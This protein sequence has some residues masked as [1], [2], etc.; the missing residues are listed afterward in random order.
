MGRIIFSVEGPVATIE[1]DNPGAHNAVD[2][3]MRESLVAAYERVEAD[4]DIRVAIMRG[5]GG[6]FCAGGSI[7][8]YLEAKVFGPD[9]DALP[10][11]P[12]PYPARKP[13]IAAMTGYALG[14]GFALALS[15]D[16]RV[17]GRGAKMGP[18]GMKFGAVQGAQTISR[19]TR[20]IGASRAL[21]VLL[22]SKRID[23]EEAERIGLA[24]AL[25][26]D[27]EVF[28]T[29]R[30]MAETVAAYSPWSVAMTKKL[31]YET[32]HLPLDESIAREDA[33]AAEGYR[34]PEALAAFGAFKERKN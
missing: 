1:L 33:V 23:G 19:L 30:A 15:C 5:A 7:D 17:V 8:G 14:G 20:L 21:G 13:Y 6:S 3:P 16:L 4:D 9:A 10:K 27:G 32:Q 31:V 12:R 18:T 26:D 22:L 29:A 2:A 28:A 24:H 34:R 25:V 11:I